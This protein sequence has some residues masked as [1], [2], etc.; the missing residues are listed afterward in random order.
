MRRLVDTEKACLRAKDLTRQLLAFARG[1]LPVKKPLALEPHGARIDTAHPAGRQ[2]AVPA[3]T[4]RRRCRRSTPTPNRLH[5]LALRAADERDARHAASGGA[6]H[7]RGET[8]TK[9]ETTSTLPLPPGRLRTPERA[10]RGAQA[11]RR[12]SCRASS[13]RFS[14]PR[15]TPV[16]WGWRRV[17]SSRAT[18]TGFMTVDSVAELRHDVLPVPAR[19]A[20]RGA[21]HEAAAGAARCRC[22][23]RR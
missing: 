6:I 13:S 22:G 15:N 16:G 1:G 10:R 20:G 12:R 23:R 19:A 8:V 2:R 14:P 5:Q 3:A 11:S 9:L 7:V 21:L 17:F 4:G 18:T